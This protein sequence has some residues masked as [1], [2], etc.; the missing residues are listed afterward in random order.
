MAYS[1]P[2]K[3]TTKSSAFLCDNNGSKHGHNNMYICLHKQLVFGFIWVGVPQVSH[4][5]ARPNYYPFMVY[6]CYSW[7]GM[8]N[9]YSGV[10]I[11]DKEMRENFPP[12]MY[13]GY[14]PLLQKGLKIM[15]NAFL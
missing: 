14:K 4:I 9:K 2:H 1:G 6:Y 10:I 13:N 15:K 7:R 5:S 12:I 11:T 3:M 8:V